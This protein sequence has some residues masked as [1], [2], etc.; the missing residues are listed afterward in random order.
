MGDVIQ[1]S[2]F[3]LPKHK[4]TVELNSHLVSGHCHQSSRFRTLLTVPNSHQSSRN[5]DITAC[6]KGL[7]SFLKICWPDVCWLPENRGPEVA[8]IPKASF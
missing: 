7:K 8:T 2:N 6:N 4:E 5:I 3:E 1:M